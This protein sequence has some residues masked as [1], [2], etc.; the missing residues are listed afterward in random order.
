MI[1]SNLDKVKRVW[2]QAEN[3]W[4]VREITITVNLS[5]SV[6]LALNSMQTFMLLYQT[7]S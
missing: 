1:R 2:C 3:E 6:R 4:N 7:K 5:W